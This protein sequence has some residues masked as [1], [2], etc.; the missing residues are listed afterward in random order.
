MFILKV[1]KEYLSNFARSS[2]RIAQIIS[3]M[4]GPIRIQDKVFIPFLSAS[5]IAKKV[6]EL[7]S[8]INRDYAGKN[9]VFIAILNG[10]FIFAADLFRKLSIEA[11]ISFIK[12][13][14]YKGTVSSGSLITTI[15]LEEREIVP[16]RHIIL[17]EDIID[18]GKTLHAFL[19]QLQHREPASVKIVTLLY[20]PGASQHPVRP[21]YSGFEIPDQFVVG[22]GMDYNGQGRNYPGILQLQPGTHT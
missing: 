18:T 12:L 10:A 1:R 11:E 13:A 7:A 5:Q 19:P 15:G 4:S 9:P 8:A 14:S 22:Y 21:D 20:K 6:N 2:N 17:V 3:N 16:G